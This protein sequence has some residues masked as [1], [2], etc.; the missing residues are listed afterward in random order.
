MEFSVQSSTIEQLQTECL[1]V[2]VYQDHQ[3][4]S[5]AVQLDQV[6]GGY[7]T[8]L[9]QMGDLDGSVGQ[10]LLLHNV[11]NIKSARVLLVGCG[12]QDELT[13]SQYKKIM[14]QMMHA[15]NATAVQQAVCF[16]TELMVKQR[17][18]YWNIRFAIESIQASRYVYD[19]F[20]SIKAK[21][22]GKLTQIIFNVANQQDLLEAERGLKHAQ[23]I[24]S[25]MIYAKN[26]ANCPPN[27]CNPAYLAELAQG[28]ATD[29][30]QIQTRIV[31]EAEMATLGM[32]AYLAVSQGSHNP[33]FLSVIEYN[34]HPDP[35]AKPI[36]LVGKGLTFDAGGIS[37]K[38][39]DAMDEMKYDMGGAAA[40]YGTMK[41][42][43]EMQ[44]PLNVVGILA[45]CE[46]MP[47]G[48]AYR[49][50][51]I[52]TTMNGLTVEV[53]NTDAEGRL[54]LCDALTY[55]ERFDP[56]CVID[57][58]TLTGACMVALGTH[59][60]G[61]MSTHNELADE[62]FTAASQAN[63]KVW[64]LP[65]GEE[66]QE[67]LKSNFADLANIGGRF[68]GAIT[69]G[70]F[71]SNFTQKYRWA[72]LDIAGTAWQ[73]GVAK[74]ATGRPVPLLAQ[75]LINRAQQE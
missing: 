10:S 32:N 37:L 59:N 71:L 43:A 62:L 39:S 41:A 23:A 13:E 45:G 70:Q 20:K 6:S 38:P 1:I 22:V 2:G 51:D 25:G 26:M 69:A 72:H 28:L 61:L 36:V 60:S 17:T 56:A 4:S 55:V 52:L 21:V 8:R 11:P 50:G 24:A 31:D 15:I 35:S 68:G 30:Q 48:N 66:Y 53:L 9:L 74:G 16:L 44:L 34:H 14:Q 58:A 67:Q 73:S 65:L 7:L 49:P 5:A 42:L 75:F 63:D 12:K 40:V 46:N 27:I 64:R 18:I 29:Y 33:A 54:V 3:L 19:V 57:I 47:D